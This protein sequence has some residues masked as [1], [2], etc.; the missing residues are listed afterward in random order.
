[1]SSST[2]DL[3][4]KRRYAPPKRRVR[5]FCLCFAAAVSAL[6]LINWPLSY[7]CSFEA[8]ISVGV[9]SNDSYTPKR[10]LVFGSARGLWALEYW[11]PPIAGANDD[12]TPSGSLSWL[13]SIDR[14]SGTY[15]RYDIPLALVLPWYRFSFYR[16]HAIYRQGFLPFVS[17][18]IFPQFVPMACSLAATYLLARPIMRDRRRLRRGECLTCGYDLTAS[19]TL[20]P[21]CGTPVPQPPPTPASQ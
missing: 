3:G 10:E 12:P 4:D 11:T 13:I 19:P 5:W 7:Y 20:C 9:R 8:N 18:L 1:M 15:Q 14:Y 6:L 21:E 17:E 2:S 16:G